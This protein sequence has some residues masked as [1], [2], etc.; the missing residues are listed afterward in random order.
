ME[1]VEES[2]EAITSTMCKNLANQLKIL[3]SLNDENLIQKTVSNSIEEANKLLM[4]DSTASWNKLIS[5]TLVKNMISEKLREIIGEYGSSKFVKISLSIFK[6]K[7]SID[8][9][10][11]EYVENY[12]KII[13]VEIIFLV[14]NEYL[15]TFRTKGQLNSE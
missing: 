8:I 7:L 11:F 15:N 4:P 12:D 14:C 6:L 1:L 9:P 5:K 10:F 13:V 2:I 3:D